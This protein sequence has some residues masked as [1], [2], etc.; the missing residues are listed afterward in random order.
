MRSG[1]GAGARAGAISVWP[2]AVRPAAVRP[3]AARPVQ[4]ALTAAPVRDDGGDRHGGWQG[5]RQDGAAPVGRFVD[6]AAAALEG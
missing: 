4:L 5:G 3:A 1:A 2:A 6:E